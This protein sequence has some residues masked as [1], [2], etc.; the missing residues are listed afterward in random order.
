MKIGHA[1]RRWRAEPQIMTEKRIM[2]HKK[3]HCKSTFIKNDLQHTKEKKVFFSV[4]QNKFTFN[5]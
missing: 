1:K 3:A 5:Q 4:I 2:F